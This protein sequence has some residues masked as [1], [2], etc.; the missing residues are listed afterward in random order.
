MC[1]QIFII[2]II[3]MAITICAGDNIHLA[4]HIDFLFA[5]GFLFDLILCKI[6]RNYEI[7]NNLDII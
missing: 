3:T 5:I 4:D 2:H 7:I 1:A 6:V